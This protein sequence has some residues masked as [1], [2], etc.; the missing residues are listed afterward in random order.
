MNNIGELITVVIPTRNEESNIGE[1]IRSCSPFTNILVVDSNSPDKTRTIAE[2]HRARVTNFYWNKKYPKKRNWILETGE[3]KTPW[4]LFLDA[5]ERITDE[6][7]KELYKLNLNDTD[8][9]G[10]WIKY[11]NS[12]MGQK[13]VGGVSQRKLSLIRTHVRYEK[14]DIQELSDFDM[15]I[16][17]H[18]II[19]SRTG[20]IKAKLLHL[21][22]LDLIA[23]ISKHL[24]Y[25]QWES[26][27]YAIRNERNHLTVRQ[28]LKYYLIT[29]HWFP[30]FY[31]LLD[32][33]FLGRFRSGKVGF[34]YSKNKAIYFS[35]IKDLITKRE[36]F[37]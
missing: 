18:P 6:F 36:Y 1:C 30:F 12:F 14:I 2:A 19:I 32:Y 5:D 35:Q 11:S 16:H 28:K 34:I 15:E 4:V 10:F 31:F 7:I 26:S 23:Y 21:E 25:A 29:K 33:I 20:T 3:I 24:T 8:I 13:M 37:D 22:N 27:C 17:E 9:D